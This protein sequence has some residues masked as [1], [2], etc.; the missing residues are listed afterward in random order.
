MIGQTSEG[1]GQNFELRIADFEMFTNLYGFYDLN[2]LNDFNDFN[3]LTNR[4]IEELAKADRLKNIL[5][6]GE[7]LV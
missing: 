2:G 7:N 1:R 3:D 4:L 5:R 6:G